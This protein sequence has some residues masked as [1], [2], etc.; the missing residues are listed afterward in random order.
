LKPGKSSGKYTSGDDRESTII[1]CNLDAETPRR[2][3]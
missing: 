3:D 2:R 1:P